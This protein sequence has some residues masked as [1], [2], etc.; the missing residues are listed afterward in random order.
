[1]VILI[2]LGKYNS[3]ILYNTLFVTLFA[4]VGVIAG[5]HISKRLNEQTFSKLIVILLVIL[6]FSM[7]I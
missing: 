4:M 7:I 6:G 5:M 3:V 1:M 2:S